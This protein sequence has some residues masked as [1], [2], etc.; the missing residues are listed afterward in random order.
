MKQNKNHRRKRIESAWG[1]VTKV[2]PNPSF[3]L[4]K[5]PFLDSDI[6]NI[7]EKEGRKK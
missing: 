4:N 1:T 5:S 2:A 7:I 3:G 6:F